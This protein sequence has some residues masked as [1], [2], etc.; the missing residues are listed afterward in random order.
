M[1]L[2][3]GLDGGLRPSAKPLYLQVKYSLLKRIVSGEWK[4]GAM[5]PSELQLAK[6]YGLSQGTVRKAVAGIADD[7][8]VTR[9]AG[10]G[11][12][13]SSY[14][15]DQHDPTRFRRFFTQ[16]GRRLVGNDAHYVSCSSITAPDLVAEGLNIERGLK[17]TEIIRTRFIEQRP[18]LLESI[19]LN[20][21]ICPNA[22]QVFS[23][24]KPAAIYLALEQAFQLLIL[25]VDEKLVSRMPSHE[26]RER[27]CID[28]GIPV[29]EVQRQAFS[30][31]QRQVEFRVS[32]CPGNG[33]ICYW[34]H[35]Q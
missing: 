35:Y 1:L 31:D 12:F 4:P 3:E 22:E 5:L 11:T 15:S 18:V 14:N 9:H 26:E 30:L 23:E 7:G 21:V 2:T 25:S 29:L 28:K 10:K 24:T 6:E 19:Y 13:V 17:V 20:S 27:L 32:V 34:N 16:G 33:E 8:V